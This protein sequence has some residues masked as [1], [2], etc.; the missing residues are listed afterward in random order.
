MASNNIYNSIA[1]KFKLIEIRISYFFTYVPNFRSIRWKIGVFPI[2]T[3]YFQ[4]IIGQSAITGLSD[5]QNLIIS[6]SRQFKTRVK[7]SAR[8]GQSYSFFRVD[9]FASFFDQIGCIQISLLTYIVYRYSDHTSKRFS[10]LKNVFS[11][12]FQNSP[13]SLAKNIDCMDCMD[14]MTYYK[15]IDISNAINSKSPPNKFIRNE[16]IGSKTIIYSFYHLFLR[17]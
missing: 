9:N 1:T 17:S 10:I 8:Y 2:Q 5:R 12:Y 15:F 3:T 6:R 14:C 7:I 16:L 13:I 11:V 4:P